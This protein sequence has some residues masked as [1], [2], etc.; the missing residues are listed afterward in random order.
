M[1]AHVVSFTP[2]A[3]LTS[4]ERRTLVDDVQ[5][6]LQA[7]PAIRRARLGRRRQFGY[8]YDTAGPV[9]F[10]FVMILEF[11]TAEDLRAYLHHPDH[12]ALGRWFYQGSEVALAQD[13]ELVE[14]EAL[15][16]RA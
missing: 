15:T 10:E 12:V 6:A 5:R 13:F 11:D 14:A 2:R 4:E 7:I 16:E 1:I 9:H 3:S 8:A